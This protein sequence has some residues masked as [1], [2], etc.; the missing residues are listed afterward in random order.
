[1]HG[2][3]VT[4]AGRLVALAFVTALMLGL[5]LPA[6]VLAEPDGPPSALQPA[7]PAAAAIAELHNVVLIIAVAVFLIVEGLLLVA[8]FR[9]RRAPKD[10][11]IPVQVHGN[12]RLEIAWTVA[13]ALVV[14]ALFVM[15][16]R[17]Q[18]TIDATAFSNQPGVPI[19]VEVVGHQWWWEFRY[20][21]FGF[22]TAG[23]MVIPVGRVINLDITSVDV[24]HS[25]WAP[26]L[27]GKTDAIGG[28]INESVLRA[29][30]PGEYYGQCAELCGVSHANM[31]FVVSV[32]SEEEFAAW[33][34]AQAQDAVVSTDPLAQ[35]G[36][37]V[38][39]GG[40]CVGCHVI[41]GIPQA[42]GKAGP[43]LTHV[44]SRPYI[45]GGV[46]ANTAHNLGRWLSN[47]PGVK[48]GSLMPNL[49]LPPADV[50]A[51]VAYLQSLK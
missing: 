50:D 6:S 13:P 45:A 15:T 30:R 39:A 35:A 44:G 34:R 49:N 22:T 37:Q 29:S 10:D 7:S 2:F 5:A 48:A 28:L 40:P 25:F 42:V 32:V 1:M 20:P 46:L 4:R 43:D 17:A 51:L 27:N 33:L 38:F 47:P 23:Q 31:R 41:R 11:S 14:V 21:D 9:F 8:A 16:V 36:Q 19:R 12:T 18:Q 3:K 24:I 26:E